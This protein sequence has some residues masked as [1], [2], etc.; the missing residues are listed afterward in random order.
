[1]NTLASALG[2]KNKKNTLNDQVI[3]YSSHNLEKRTSQ[4]AIEQFNER[5]K[6][7]YPR[8]LKYSVIK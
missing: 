5:E 6:F 2:L 3:S 4:E 1:M 7:K 8:V